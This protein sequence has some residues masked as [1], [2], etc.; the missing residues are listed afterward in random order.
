MFPQEEGE[1]LE[2]V[3]F[4]YLKW[5]D[6]TAD[7]SP[8]AVTEFLTVVRQHVRPAQ[9]GPMVVHCRYAPVLL[10]FHGV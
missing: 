3:H 2:V 6:M 4:H 1:E 7:L 9:S 5:P 8:E 10:L